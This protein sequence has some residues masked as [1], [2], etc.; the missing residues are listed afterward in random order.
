MIQRTGG[1]HPVKITTRKTGENN[2]LPK[3]SKS[4][5]KFLLMLCLLL[6]IIGHLCSTTTTSSSLIPSV[7]LILLSLLHLNIGKHSKYMY[8]FIY[9]ATHRLSCCPGSQWSHGW[10]ETSDWLSLRPTFWLWGCLLSD[11]LWLSLSLSLG[12][13]SAGCQGGSRIH[14]E[15]VGYARDSSGKCNPTLS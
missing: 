2:L 11:F 6:L 7:T 12:L 14:G 9:V 15:I 8:T 10:S 5:E 3:L 1:F 13:W 4:V